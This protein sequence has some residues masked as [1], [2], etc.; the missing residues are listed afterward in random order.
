MV[1]P[2]LCSVNRVL[3]LGQLRCLTADYYFR[4]LQLKVI[5]RVFSLTNALETPWLDRISVN[6]G[7]KM[8]DMPDS[9]LD[10]GLQNQKFDCKSMCFLL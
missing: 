3:F 1:A 10:P 9:D 7:N 2:Y 5:F 4:M 6:G 8:Q